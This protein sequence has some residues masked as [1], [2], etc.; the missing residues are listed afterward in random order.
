[1]F[2]KNKIKYILLIVAIFLVAVGGVLFYMNIPSATE[3]PEKEQTSQEEDDKVLGIPEFITNKGI[4]ENVVTDANGVRRNSS[5]AFNKVHTYGD[6]SINS[7]QLYFDSENEDMAHVKFILNN[8]GSKQYNNTGINIRFIFEDGSK[9]EKFFAM[10]LDTTKEI[11]IT[12]L[13]KVM[14]AVDYEFSVEEVVGEP[15]G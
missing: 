4:T 3:Q 14:D 6:Y 7:L 12:I 5:E 15:L 2:M 10:T 9:S 1:M 11:E 13:H 8:N